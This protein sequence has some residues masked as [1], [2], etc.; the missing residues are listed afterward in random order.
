[1]Q[2]P[3]RI[4]FVLQYHFTRFQGGS[5]E[6]CWLL[7][8]ELVRRG[9]DVH[10][11]SEM[12]H[13]PAE[14]MEGVTLHGLPENPSRWRGNRDA[15]VRLFHDLRPGVVYNGMYDLYTGLSLCNVSPRAVKVWVSS[16]ENDGLFWRKLRGLRRTMSPARFW[17]HLPE[18]C[19]IYWAARS[20]VA[21]ADIVLAQRQEQVP[22]LR[23]SGLKPVLFRNVLPIVD[24]D[25]V[26]DHSGRPL[27]LWAGSL[28][29]VKRPTLFMDLARSCRDLDADFVMIGLV[30]DKKYAPIVERTAKELPN[31][32]YDGEVPLSRVGEHFRRSHLCV[33]TSVTEGFGTSLI[34]AWMHGVPVVTV[35]V[36]P[37]LLLSQGGLGMVARSPGELQEVVRSLLADP[38]RRKEIGAKARA[39]VEQEHDLKKAVDRLESLLAERGVNVAKE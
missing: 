25:R 32:R 29:D 39:Y 2:N 26:Q 15:L 12:D 18:Y 36:D 37:D 23:R 21:R 5:E 6:Q 1:M 4:L 28:K 7:A 38:E 20:G 9:W 14:I 13:P 34:H 16:A 27:V 24:A 33:N 35:G 3:P 10:Y 31:F 30:Q 8:T 17:G 22:E 11:A 19:R